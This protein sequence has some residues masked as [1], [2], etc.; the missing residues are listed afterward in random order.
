M[1][2][3]LLFWLLVACTLTG[4][5]SAR[6]A[7]PFSVSAE[8]SGSGSAL[9]ARNRGPAP[10]SV[11]LALSGADNVSSTQP[12]PVYAVV[13]PCSEALLLQIRPNHPGRGLRFSTQATFSIGNFHATPDPRATYRLP[14]ANGRSF[15]ISQAPGGPLTTHTADDSEH[16]VD[17]TMPENTPVVAARDGVVIETEATNRFGGKDRGL[18]AMANYV[19]ILHAD[20]TVATYAHLAPGGVRVRPGERVSAGT[21]IG[22]SGATGYTSGPHLHFVV[23]KLVRRNDRF[24]MVSVPFRFSV[25]DPPHVFTPK[26]GQLATADYAAPGRAP[27]FV[28]ARRVEQPA[29][30]VPSGDG[31][32][33][34]QAR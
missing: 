19:R 14:F 29:A 12:L 30:Q 11:R 2:R 16:A 6:Q 32:R 22:Q 5:A 34:V 7:Y 28:D 17:F 18:L 25:G 26:F 24:A 8:R 10:V 31:K 9:I 13:R 21:V 20:E 15:V 3:L 27:P 23:Q 4:A 33:V 1:R